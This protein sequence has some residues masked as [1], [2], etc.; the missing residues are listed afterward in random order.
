MKLTS[1]LIP[2]PRVEPKPL[3]AYCGRAEEKGNCCYYT[4]F[5]S[6]PPCWMARMRC[7]LED[8]L[9]R[10]GYTRR[11]PSCPVETVHVLLVDGIRRGHVTKK[12]MPF[13]SAH[14]WRQNKG[15]C[16][17]N[18]LKDETLA[19]RPGFTASWHA[20]VL[21]FEIPQAFRHAV[22]L[23]ATTRFAD[24]RLTASMSV[25]W[26]KWLSQSRIN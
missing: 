19:Y 5:Q 1:H 23:E 6:H 10:T 13:P 14:F 26:D 16:W 12:T 3:L 21:C 9:R 25:Y 17:G 4:V 24:I 22:N 2:K 15:R 8:N 20:R 7:W 11:L 18:V